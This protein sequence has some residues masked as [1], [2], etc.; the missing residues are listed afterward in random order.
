MLYCIYCVDPYVAIFPCRMSYIQCGARDYRFIAVTFFLQWIQYGSKN[1]F[2]AYAPSFFY[3]ICN[4]KLFMEFSDIVSKV[5]FIGKFIYKLY[6]YQYKL[7]LGRSFGSRGILS[8]QKK[9]GTK[10]SKTFPF[11]R[12]PPDFQTFLRPLRKD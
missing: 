3:L 7:I 8:P 4:T 11:K 5:P 10:R 1:P 6:V 2:F 9:F 12:P